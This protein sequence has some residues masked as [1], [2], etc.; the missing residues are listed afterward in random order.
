M[1]SEFLKGSLLKMSNAQL[2]RVVEEA[3]YALHTIERCARIKPGPRDRSVAAA[4]VDGPA[5]KGPSRVELTREDLQ[6]QIDYAR[7]LLHRRLV[8]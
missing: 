3:Q 2:V 6:A 8:G 1:M 4:V 7:V 5:R